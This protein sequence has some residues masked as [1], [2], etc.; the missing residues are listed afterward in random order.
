M[1]TVLVFMVFINRNYEPQW[2]QEFKTEQECVQQAEKLTQESSW[3][4][5][6]RLAVCVPKLQKF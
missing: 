1:N 2:V 4:S 5:R 3:G 6:K